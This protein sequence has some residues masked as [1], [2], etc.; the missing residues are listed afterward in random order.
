MAAKGTLFGKPRDEV[1]KRPGAF[2]AKAD[3][4]GKSTSAYA[5]QVLKPSSSASTRTKKQAALAQTFKK[6]RAGKAKFAAA[7]VLASA[8]VARADAA[9]KGCPS[10]SLTPT[11][12]TAIGAT[13]DVVLARAAPALLLEVTATAGTATAQMEISCDDIYWAPVQNSVM[14][15]TPPNNSQA[16]SVLAPTCSYRARVTACSS[17]AVRVLYACSGAH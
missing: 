1:V 14:N 17:C 5:R 13:P 15:L 6:L 7:L 9:S 12:I 3:K 16:V 11:P 8:L 4:A 2:T 10:G